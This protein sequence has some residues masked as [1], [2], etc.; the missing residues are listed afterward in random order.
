MAT[1]VE[2]KLKAKNEA[3][4]QIQKVKTD[5][6]GMASALGGGV[7]GGVIGALGL[8]AIDSAIGQVSALTG[9]IVN[10]AIAAGEV[11][12]LRDAFNELSAGIGQSAQAMIEAS[13]LG[14]RGLVKDAD[15]IKASN[16]A[17]MLEV[18][19]NTNEMS[20]VWALAEKNADALGLTMEEVFASIVSGVNTQRERTLAAAGVLVDVDKAMQEYAQSIG[21]TAD[22]LDNAQRKQAVLNAV[23]A[24]APIA[25]SGIDSVSDS[26]QRLAVSLDKVELSIGKAFGP[27]T[28][29]ILTTF[30]NILDAAVQREEQAQQ[31]LAQMA[32]FDKGSQIT[33]AMQPY[34]A[35]R[36][37]L[38]QVLQNADTS[39][40][41]LP[42][43]IAKSKDAWEELIPLVN[44]YNNAAK[45]TGAPPID[46][47][48]LKQGEL[49][50]VNVAAG[51]KALGDE[52]TAAGG[53]VAAIQ[54]QLA[55][56]AGQADT[57]GAALRNVW[58]NAAGALGAGQA[59]A[60][61]QTAQKN[62]E[63]LRQAWYYEG[64]TAEEIQFKEAEYLQNTTQGV[65][66]KV[67]EVE[68]LTAAQVGHG[69]AVNAVS[70]EYN[71]LLGKISGIVNESMNLGD[72]KWP[73]SDSSTRN[74]DAVNENAR[75]M[76]AIAN[77]GLQG[78]PWLE[79]LKNEAPAAYADLMIRIA[80]GMNAQQAAQSIMSEFQ[81][82]LR[83]ELLDKGMIK[84]RVKAMIMG[85]SNAAALANEIATEL[86]AE[87]GI[88][89][90]EALAK[91]QQALGVT[92]TGGTGEGGQTADMTGQGSAAGSTFAAGFTTTAGGGALVGTIVAG[93]VLSFGQFDTA[94]KNAGTR[95]GAAFYAA[96]Q[97]GLAP[98]LIDLLVTLVTPGV[99]AAIDTQ[100]TQTNP[101]DT[102]GNTVYI[103]TG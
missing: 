10:M 92:A 61:F 9:E 53:P 89:M 70:Q 11:G 20:A 54:A 45:L 81:Q 88:S 76:A 64:R 50:Y 57:T 14:S 35:A 69:A 51:A 56:L 5:L 79:E 102:G 46:I 15:L 59:L 52:S 60:G 91:T 33:Q 13:R 48:L 25:G 77:E 29:T 49:A 30:T 23:M 85:E 31:Q 93:M 73:G 67:A 78:Q 95:W 58:I 36:A 98:Q 40:M 103:P 12:E 100:G 37:E 38:T 90:P 97:T 1:D 42:N 63:S 94:G 34:L 6:G 16:R 18:I 26:A 32:L 4:A 24:Q 41:A 2:I 22:Q 66:S 27:G 7:V 86:A 75:R 8:S 82:G 65:Q 62:L 99:K 71:D 44:E 43:A 21:T 96:A 74:G 47:A 17:M 101:N 83:P 19:D 84:E 39:S 28:I 68:K 87:M 72:I 80:R 55:A 3:S